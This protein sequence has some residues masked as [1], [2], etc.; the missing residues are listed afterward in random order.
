MDPGNIGPGDSCNIPHIV[1]AALHDHDK[2]IAES[3]IDTCTIESVIKLLQLF[4]ETMMTI[5]IY[6][7]GIEYHITTNLA[8]VIVSLM[9]LYVWYTKE[10]AL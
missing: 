5:Y 7:G 3:D 6:M 1:F 4:V 8:I 2:T 9:L 10:D